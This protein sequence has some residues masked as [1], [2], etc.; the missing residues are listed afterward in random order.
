MQTLHVRV[1][2]L[3]AL[4][5]SWQR[6]ANPVPVQ[7]KPGSLESAPG[8]GPRGRGGQIGPFPKAASK[9]SVMAKKS[10]GLPW[11]VITQGENGTKQQV[12]GWEN[13]GAV[14]GAR[15]TERQGVLA[16]RGHLIPEEEGACL[17]Y[18]PKSDTSESKRECSNSCTGICDSHLLRAGSPGWVFWVEG[19]RQRLGTSLDVPIWV[20][21]GQTQAERDTTH[22]SGSWIGRGVCGYNALPDTRFHTGK[23]AR[24]ESSHLWKFT[25]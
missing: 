19:G 22:P 23:N 20:R 25:N 4:D 6:W 14:Q 18:C 11:A 9:R 17:I 1:L 8:K 12:G 7:E 3:W 10:E 5:S 16:E 13:T 2:P 21:D 15:C 24:L